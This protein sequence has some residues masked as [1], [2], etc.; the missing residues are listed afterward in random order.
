MAGWRYFE[1]GEGDKD[2][3]R[4]NETLSL[5]FQVEYR[6]REGAWLIAWALRGEARLFFA[7]IEDTPHREIT[8]AEVPCV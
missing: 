3:W 1:L 8:E 6:D 5:G 4:V 7:D 2:Y